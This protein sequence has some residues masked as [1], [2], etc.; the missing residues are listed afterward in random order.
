MLYR[1]STRVEEA[2]EIIEQARVT[3]SEWTDEGVSEAAA[4]ET[5]ATDVVEAA[6][7]FRIYLGAAAGVGKTYAMLNEGQRRG[8]GVPT[9]SSGSSSA[10]GGGS[11]RS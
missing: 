7:H 3:G 10:T 8:G 1:R 5:D 2:A 11:P 6:G 4:V 9:S